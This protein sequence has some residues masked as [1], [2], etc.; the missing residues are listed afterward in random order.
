SGVSEGKAPP[1][2]VSRGLTRGLQVVDMPAKGSDHHAETGK[3][4]KAS[5]VSG[6]SVSRMQAMAATAFAEAP[7]TLIEGKAETAPL[8]REKTAQQ[9]ATEARAR[10][11]EGESCSECGNFTL[12]RNGTCMKCDT[13][14]S[15]TGCS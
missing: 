12:V 9:K 6:P 10:G 8:P 14:G 3:P 2:P 4:T 15:T 1:A 11:Y 7:E 13:C 5:A